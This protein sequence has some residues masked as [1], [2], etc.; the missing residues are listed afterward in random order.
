MSS[1][2]LVEL[3]TMIEPISIESGA[4]SDVRLDQSPSSTYS[5]LRDAR[6]TAR[7]A[8]RSNL[9]DNNSNAADEHWRTVL[10]LAPSILS[11]ESKD[12]EVACWYTEA[13]LRKSGFQG[14]R[15]GFRL[16]RLLIEN[17]WD[18]IYPM[19]DEDGMATRVAALT[20]LNGEG[21]EG[22]LMVPMRNVPITDQLEP[23][24]T[25]HWL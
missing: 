10:D 3:D 20:G 17:Y 9:F 13:L 5:R 22:V 18:E 21:A 7:A 23:G 24:R 16:I 4:G 12:L 1:P 14:L 19:P 2:Q 25:P 11:G 15:D 8:E 6:K